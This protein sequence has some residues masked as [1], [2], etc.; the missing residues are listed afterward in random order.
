LNVCTVYLL[1]IFLL[2][3]GGTAGAE[4]GISAHL[5]ALRAVGPEG[6]GNREASRAWRELA[7]SG[8]AELPAILAAM[9][10]AGPLAVNWIRAAVDAIAERE[11]ARGVKLPAEDLEK[12]ILETG[13]HPRARRLAFEWLSR[14]DPD[15]PGRLIPGMENDPSL[16]L[17]RE[18]VA[19]LVKEAA[20][21]R[22]KKSPRAGDA[23]RKAL[24]CARDEDQ[25]GAIARGLKEL[26]QP[27]DLARHYGFLM[28]WHLIG[29]FDHTGSKAFDIAYPPEREIDLEKKYPGKESEVG[30][31]EHTT[32][33]DHGL[34]DLNRALGKHKGAI[35]YALAE[36]RSGERRRAQLRLGCINGWKI[37]LNGKFLFGHEEYHHGM[38]MDQFLVPCELQRGMN[39][40]LLKVCQ[41]EQTESFAQE[42]RFQLRVCDETGTA[43]L[44]EGR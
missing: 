11:I 5:D 37:W 3:L 32:G 6:R 25:V 14:V 38:K 15:A 24:T 2:A 10:G 4:S 26:G 1:A 18:A 8:A 7:K 43:V 21:L 9:D 12:F 28:E 34:V 22:E 23:Y 16:E 36:F 27:V 29:P 42:W 39:R 40:I 41:N 35:A 20:E 33:D 13:H 17:R 30:W 44:P 31:K 19:L